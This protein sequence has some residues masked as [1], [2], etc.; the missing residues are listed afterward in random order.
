MYGTYYK[1][2]TLINTEISNGLNLSNTRTVCKVRGLLA[3]RCCYAEG[4]DECYAKL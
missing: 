1:D 2:Y 4:G 3:V